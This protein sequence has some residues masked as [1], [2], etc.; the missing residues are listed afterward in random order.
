LTRHAPPHGAP[1]ALKARAMMSAGACGRCCGDAASTSPSSFH[2]TMKSPPALHAAAAPLSHACRGCATTIA[3]VRGSPD[4]AN[5]RAMTSYPRPLSLVCIHAT[6]KLPAGSVSIDGST[7]SA[8]PAAATV[9]TSPAARSAPK[10][11]ARMPAG[12]P[13]APDCAHTATQP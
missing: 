3:G 10:R 13:S 8:S 5:R 6:T 9:I 11:R 2:A 1:D 7:G 12:R 4:V